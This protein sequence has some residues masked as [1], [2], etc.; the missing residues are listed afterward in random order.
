MSWKLGFFR[1]WVLGSALW[2]TY[3]GYSASHEFLKPAAFGGNYQYVV[4]TKE[5]PW[6]TDWKKPLYEIAYSP[7]E[8]RF[9]Q[10]FASLEDTYIEGWEK[11]VRDGS[12]TTIEF[13]DSTFLYLSSQ[14]T[15]EDQTYLAQLFWHGQWLRYFKKVGYWLLL[16]FGPPAAALLSGL[17]IRWVFLGFTQKRAS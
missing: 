15:N 9:P 1:L 10:E 6:A 17:A 13:P 11:S 7:K 4:Q 5:M 2:I 16:A 8:G 3:V 14:W 12:L